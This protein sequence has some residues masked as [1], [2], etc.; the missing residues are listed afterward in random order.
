M[1]MN[2]QIKLYSINLGLAK[3]SRENQLYRMK[4]LNDGSLFKY[5]K[6][7]SNN[8]KANLKTD[9]WDESC[10]EEF[11][12]IL[13]EDVS[14][15]HLNSINKQLVSQIKEKIKEYDLLDE[16]NN[17]HIRQVDSKY[18]KDTNQIAFF[19]N[20]LT[21]TL[22]IDGDH[23]TLDFIVIEV[24][25]TDMEI[26][27]Q[28]IENGLIITERVK[29][30]VDE[31]DVDIIEVKYNKYRFF[32]AGAGQTRQKKF[33]MIKNELWE[34][35]EKKLMCGL[36]I[37]TVN[38]LGGMNINKFNAYLSLNNSASDIV[39]EFD[40][41]RCIVVD[42]FTEIINEEVDYITRD[43]EV[44]DGEITYTTKSG[45]TITR[46]KK[47]TVWDIKRKFMDVPIDFMDGAGICLESVF[48]K[49]TQIRMPWFKGILCPIDYKKYIKENNLKTKITDI[50]GKEYDI[51]DD[52]IR[53]IFTKSQFKM[54]KY[55]KNI[56]DE[57]G[58]IFITGWEVYK[59]CYKYYECTCNKC[60]ED[61]DDLK[62]MKINY[63]MLQTLTDMS[64]EQIE[65]LTTPTKELIS[66]VHIDRDEQLKFLGATLDTRNRDYTQEI[67]RLYPE[68]L[69]SKY[70]KKQLKDTITSFKKEAKSG[71]VKLKSKRVFIIPDL[72]HFMSIL[73][74]DGSDFALESKEVFF[75]EYK[76]SNKLALLRS[77]HLSR[78]WSIN[79]NVSNDK[80]K[81]FK[82]NAVY[83]NAKDLMSK[84]LMCDW[85]G[86]E[87]LIIENCKEQQWLI[88][89]AERQMKH[90][91]PL[92]YEMGGGG[93]TEINMVNTFNS[94]RF[95]YEKSNIGK[96]SNTLTNI[97]SKDDCN[98]NEDNIKKL[99]AYNNWIIDSA[100]K[101]ELPKLP[102]DIRELMNNKTYPH[103]FQFAKNKKK[104]EVRPVGSGVIDR[105]CKSIDNIKYADFDYSKGFGKFKSASLMNN[106]K[107]EINYEVIDFYIKLEENTRRLIRKYALKYKDD[108]SGF[109][110]KELAY[111]E[112]RRDLLDYSKLIGADYLDIIDMI[113]KYSF[114]KDEMKLAFVFNVFGAV[115]INNLNKNIKLS[116]DDKTTRMC[117]NCGKRFKRITNNQ[118]RCEK[119]SKETIREKDRTRKIKLIPYSEKP[120]K[121][122]EYKD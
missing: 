44:D 35:Y 26:V 86:D 4:Y 50:Y 18:F 82:T 74:G 25:N 57:N 62:N 56:L 80:T 66:K 102:K 58:D 46:D 34:K 22:G 32:S 41:D 54:C 63:Q 1:S 113:I 11:K 75:N 17:K 111:T 81:Y 29:N 68:I 20:A 47:K 39:E 79:N 71:R 76:D 120:H 40:I 16:R 42:D 101:L 85:D 104:S 64:D 10:G 97:W 96:V 110:Y 2:K 95:V 78:E 116:I 100:K 69:S 24:G 6:K 49:N 15:K 13:S 99:C 103:F 55:Y 118:I 67:I 7:I 90:L 109:N 65:L 87:A 9:V 3:S 70:I 23:P 119:C 48:S 52:D 30:G 37:N 27:R 83:V 53:V 12:K 21:R 73:F 5:K 72:V 92:Y 61:E 28:V 94:L 115:I 107:I 108:D 84:I 77:P 98:E 89:L 122:H 51:I 93:N 117:E 88:D 106:K 19:E 91:R 8:I 114:K 121:W 38:K 105:I 14:Y 59:A 43:D 31:D 112:A 45:K 60:L 33:M 36:S